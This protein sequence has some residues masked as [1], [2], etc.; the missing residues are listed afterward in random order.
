MS[1]K[2]HF[3]KRWQSSQFLLLSCALT[4]TSQQIDAH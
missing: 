2:E 4:V 3:F 1:L